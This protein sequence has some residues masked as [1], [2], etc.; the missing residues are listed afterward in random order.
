M[1][2]SDQVAIGVFVGGQSSRMGSPKGLLPMPGAEGVCVLEHLLSTAER[3]QMFP[4]FLVGDASPYAALLSRLPHEVTLLDDDPA[5]VGPL[6]G[7]AALLKACA[8]T[9]AAGV[10][11][12]AC[13]MP[14]V[15]PPQIRALVGA[16]ALEPSAAII[17]PAPVSP[18]SPVSPDSPVSSPGRRTA[19]AGAT[20]EIYEP[21]LS[22]YR[23]T[24]VLPAIRALLRDGHH[25]LQRLFVDDAL[26]GPVAHLPRGPFA[27]ALRDWDTPEDVLR[28][29]KGQPDQSALGNLDAKDA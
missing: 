21:M 25:G 6:G 27:S 8:Q 17:T 20:R 29:R 2:R 23:P 12:V 10:I 13:D 7:L 4:V 9:D 18:V 14:F 16:G 22:L 5:G 28:Y 26:T 3:A 24:R 11:A 1:T 15:Q 19:K